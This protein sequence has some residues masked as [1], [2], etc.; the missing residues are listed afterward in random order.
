MRYP[1]GRT[2][3]GEDER[4]SGQ[5]EETNGM[6]RATTLDTG[7]VCCCGK[8]CKNAKGV[9]IHQGKSGC[10]SKLSQSQ[11]TGR[12]G[13][14]EEA[15]IQEEHHRDCSVHGSEGEDI[16]G[17]E[18]E[19]NNIVEERI[20]RK[21]RVKWPGNNEKDQW[22]RFDEDLDQTLE[23]TLAGGVDR[24]FESMTTIAYNM[25]A[26]MFGTGEKKERVSQQHKSNRREGEIKKLRKELRELTKK[27]RRAESEE[28][29]AGYAD[30]RKMLR[31]RMMSLLRAERSRKR[32]RDRAKARSQFTADPFRFTKEL[33]GD[34]T[35]GQ[36]KCPLDKVEEH[37]KRVYIVIPTV[38]K[39]WENGMRW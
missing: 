21:A 19:E 27:Y 36:L 7:N 29:K 11:R 3:V 23:C 17:I 32:R 9:K 4:P 15:A 25:G 5:N 28:Q 39:S 33:L 24:K 13:Q 35:S 38:R 16:G 8:V 37:L 10:L 6:E 26:W 1:R 14:T 31:T 18:Q 34:K 12:P 30:I 22:K 2:R 20:R